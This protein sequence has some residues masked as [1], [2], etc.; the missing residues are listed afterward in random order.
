MPQ[1]S[2]GRGVFQALVPQ[3]FAMGI[4]IRPP[5]RFRSRL[6]RCEVSLRLS[7]TGYRIG[8]IFFLH[9]AISAGKRVVKAAAG[10]E[11]TL[12]LTDK[13]VMW[14]AADPLFCIPECR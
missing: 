14:I 6:W 13:G 11:H 3:A 1:V 4:L 5:P 12:F 10:R 8:F 7:A 2:R 9:A